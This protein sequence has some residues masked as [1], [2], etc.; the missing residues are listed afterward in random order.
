MPKLPR[1]HTVTEFLQR[2]PVV[3]RL[4]VQWGEMD[5]FQHVNNVVYFRYQETSR[6][7]YFA[8]LTNEIKDPSFDAKAFQAG[9]GLGP[10]M[11]ETAVKF[12]YP[13]QAP[14]TILVGASAHMLDNSLNR[15]QMSHS[16]WSLTSNRLV[17]QG[18]G[19]VASF[20]YAA[21]KSQD[22]DPLIIAAV[23]SL[24]QKNSLQLEGE[25]TKMI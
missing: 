24:G 3:I 23:E 15:F 18:T 4:P 14:D 25:L 6:I 21:G 11:S 22:F 17:A 2:F 12:I 8:A 9:T 1:I 13:L 16:I 20:N 5:A 7:K 10:I 19:T